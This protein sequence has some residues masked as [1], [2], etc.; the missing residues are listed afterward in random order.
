MKGRAQGDA[1]LDLLLDGRNLFG[2]TAH[3]RQGTRDRQGEVQSGE[4]VVHRLGGQG[5]DAI[6][7]EG[8]AGVAGHQILNAQEI[9][10]LLSD[11]LTARP[12]QV[13]DRAFGLRIDIARG[14][15]T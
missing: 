1:G 6:A 11:A 13:T 5:L 15:N 4:Q 7:G 2:H 10:G 3:H 14:Q 9:T 12:Q 8:G